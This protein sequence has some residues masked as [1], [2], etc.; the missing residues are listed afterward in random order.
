MVTM[1][2]CEVM[3]MRRYVTWGHGRDENNAVLLLSIIFYN[4]SIQIET[5]IFN[6]T[7]TF[8]GS[9]LPRKYWIY[10]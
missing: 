7:S 2:I 5:S 9:S 10:T 4:I 1:P 6:E 3:T 8:I